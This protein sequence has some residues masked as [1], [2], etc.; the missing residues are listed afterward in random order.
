MPVW[1]APGEGTLQ[2][3]IWPPQNNPE[4]H[5]DPEEHPGSLSGTTTD[6]ITD[7]DF[8]TAAISPHKAATTHRNTTTASMTQL[9]SDNHQNTKNFTK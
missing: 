2:G 8:P 5:D 4:S 6:R 9:P 7:D 3:V 1:Y